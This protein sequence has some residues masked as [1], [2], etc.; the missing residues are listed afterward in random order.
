[1]KKVFSAAALFLALLCLFCGCAAGS[2]QPLPEPVN[3][4][5]VCD[6]ITLH[7]QQDAYP[8]G[9]ETMTLLLEN[10]SDRVMLYGE[11]WSFSRWENGEWN[12]RPTRENAA[13]NAIGYQLYG[14]S[15][16]E[17]T[18]STFLLKDPLT[19]GLYR[20]T[21][22]TLR[23]AN[24]GE[25][26]GYGGEYTEYPAYEV[27]F[28]VTADAQAEPP[29]AQTQPDQLPPK[30]DWE[31]YTPW[32][33]LSVCEAQG[34]SVWQYVQDEQGLMALLLRENTPENEMLKQGDLLQLRLFDRKTG[35][36]FVCFDTPAVKTDRVFALDEGGFSIFAAEGQFQAGRNGSEW[37]LIPVEE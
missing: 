28:S 34:Y 26:L 2:D 14:H 4:W 15:R 33:P 24:D 1:M 10:R 31:W 37:F 9:T 25:N 30:E 6:G 17:L 8:E 18:L 22:C 27:Q 3:H 29:R 11:G 20:I 12:P 23:V 7:L 35:D 16:G 13:F 5:T 32:A 21:G 19:E 36:F